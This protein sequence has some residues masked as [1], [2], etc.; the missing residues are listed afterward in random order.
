MI[1]IKIILQFIKD[2]ILINSNQLLQS[3]INLPNNKI[4]KMIQFFNKNLIL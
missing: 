2:Y 4:H 3:K 1:K